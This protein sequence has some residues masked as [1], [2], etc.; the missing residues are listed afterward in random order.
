M[1][2]APASSR[3]FRDWRRVRAGESGWQTTVSYQWCFWTHHSE[4]LRDFWFGANSY[5]SSVV[6]TRERT[7]QA[8]S[9]WQTTFSISG[10]IGHI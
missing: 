3:G 2:L 1:Q 4:H 7:R 9:G 10:A 8:S 5:F 6:R